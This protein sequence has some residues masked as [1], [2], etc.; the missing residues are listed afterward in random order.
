MKT[1]ACFFFFKVGFWEQ[2][3]TSFSSQKKPIIYLHSVK[4]PRRPSA[5][6]IHPDERPQGMNI[7]KNFDC[8]FSVKA[9]YG[10]KLFATVQ[11]MTFE[12]TNYHSCIDSIKVKKIT[13]FKS[14]L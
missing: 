7:S 4:E 14:K 2:C 13:K 12:S 8:T 3:R 9:R 6:V 1:M 5:L 11:S 10:E